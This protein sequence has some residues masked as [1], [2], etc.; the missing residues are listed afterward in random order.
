MVAVF[1][2]YLISLY[3]PLSNKYNKAVWNKTTQSVWQ[4]CPVSVL[5]SC[6]NDW[7]CCW[8][9]KNSSGSLGASS[10]A[11]TDEGHLCAIEARALLQLTMHRTRTTWQLSFPRS[12]R[13]LSEI[14]D[15][16]AYYAEIASLDASKPHIHK[17]M[18]GIPYPH[19]E[20]KDS[21]AFKLS[22]LL[23]ELWNDLGKLF[24]W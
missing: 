15:P 3:I 6:A 17:P 16:V 11:A 4:S 21:F 5:V 14:S 20:R 9:K 7:S 12:G 18:E 13:P 19:W 24:K 1:D 10:M 2:A 22:A 8:L 23:H